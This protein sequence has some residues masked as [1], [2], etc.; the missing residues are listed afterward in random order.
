[1]LRR[2]WVFALCIV[3]GCEPTGLRNDIRISITSENV[4]AADPLVT[5][6]TFVARNRGSIVAYLPRCG[7]NVSTAVERFDGSGWVDASGDF[8]LTNNRMDPIRL[9]PGAD[10]RVFG[11]FGDLVDFA[12]APA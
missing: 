10:T 3:A 12:F 4:L 11:R 6:V 7:E 9:D 1:M 2:F 5:R 8:C